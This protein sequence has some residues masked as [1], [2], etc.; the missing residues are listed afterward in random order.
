MSHKKSRASRGMTLVEC[1]V[2]MAVFAI[3]SLLVLSVFGF[4]TR[5]YQRADMIDKTTDEQ[6][7]Q[8]ERAAV[9]PSRDT[10]LTYDFGGNIIVIPVE[11]WQ[12]EEDGVEL[13][14]YHP[15]TT[16]P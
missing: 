13:R 7:G 6:A 8:L 12:M 16:T 5:Q 3:L 15:I 11:E 14:Y 10:S 9:A 2:A 4:A 1:V